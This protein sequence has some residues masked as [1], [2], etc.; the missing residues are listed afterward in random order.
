MENKITML[1][2]EEKQSIETDKQTQ[3]W[4]RCWNYFNNFNLF[5]FNLILTNFKALLKPP[6]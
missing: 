5:K 6:L 4:I 2:Q 1:G 3:M